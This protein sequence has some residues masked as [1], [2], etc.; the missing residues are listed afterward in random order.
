M[1]PQP[2]FVVQ[3]PFPTEGG[4]RRSVPRV[5]PALRPDGYG[6]NTG[7]VRIDEDR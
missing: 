1:A 2:G 3:A 7:F 6:S 4:L 5:S